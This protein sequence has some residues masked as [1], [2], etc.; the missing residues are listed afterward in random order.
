MLRKFCKAKEKEI[1][2]LVE[3][4]KKGQMPAPFQGERGDFAARLRDGKNNLPAIIA[5]YK[6]ASP[7]RGSICESVSVREAA[8]VYGKMAEC[9]SV[10]TEKEYFQG[11]MAF[12]EEAYAVNGPKLPLLRKDFLMDPLQIEMSAAFPCAAVLLIVRFLREKKTLQA[13]FEKAQELGLDAVF[14]IFSEEE[15]GIARACGA[16]IIQVNARNLETLSVDTGLFERIISQTSPRSHEVWIA[17]SGLERHEQL[18][19][20]RESGFHAALIGTTLMK[21]GNPRLALKKLL[22]GGEHAD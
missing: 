7:S 10:L 21:D 18:L 13:L 3:R 5:E 22:Q 2:S 4:K 11:E 14:E 20:L 12:L 17:A 15:L 8:D 16:R 6:R 1:A 9:M 19:R